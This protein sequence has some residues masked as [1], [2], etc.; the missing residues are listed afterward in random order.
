MAPEQPPGVLLGRVVAPE[1]PQEH[2]QH[3]MDTPAL[4]LGRM[5]WQIIKPSEE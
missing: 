2:R 5:A 1:E 3:R 4:F